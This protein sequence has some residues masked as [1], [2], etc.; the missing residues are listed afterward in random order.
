MATRDLPSTAST[1]ACIPD[2]YNLLTVDEIKALRSLRQTLIDQPDDTVTSLMKAYRDHFWPQKQNNA[3]HLLDAISK[4][5]PKFEEKIKADRENQA[6]RQIRLRFT[7]TDLIYC[8]AF[9]IPG[10]KGYFLAK[11][12][13][14]ATKGEF[15]ASENKTYSR[16]EGLQK[17]FE[18]QLS[19]SQLGPLDLVKS[20]PTFKFLIS[21]YDTDNVQ[22]VEKRIRETLGWLI[23]K[24]VM[25]DYKISVPTEWIIIPPSQ[26]NHLFQKVLKLRQSEDIHML[27]TRV[28][29][30]LPPLLDEEK[31]TGFEW[32]K[33]WF[34][35]NVTI[36]VRLKLNS[37]L[38]C[39]EELP[40]K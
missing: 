4:L 35:Y 9:T 17:D 21:P 33:K 12:G 40:G 1:T 24:S 37:G 5:N 22:D 16:F 31:P 38:V 19:S 18:N 10:D 11:V 15:K 26:S 23:P 20:Q 7:Q 3:I 14:T 34:E 25:N 28:L 27:D 32:K 2:K 8:L 36:S 30:K 39:I 13:M 29:D 6:Y